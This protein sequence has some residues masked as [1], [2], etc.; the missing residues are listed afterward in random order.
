MTTGEESVNKNLAYYR[1]CFDQIKVGKNKEGGK[2]LNQPILL[3]SVIDLITQ[4]LLNE[5]NITVSEPLINTFKRYWSVLSSDRFEE[6]NF[7]IPFFHLKNKTPKFWHVKFSEQYTGGRPYNIDSLRRDVEKA[8]ID[9]ELFDLLRDYNAKKELIDILI[10]AWFS[11]SQKQIEDVLTI[12]QSLQD[13]TWNELESIESSDTDAQ[14]KVYLRKSLFREAIFR[15]SVVHL[16]DYRC[17]FCRLKVTNRSL[18]Q[19][20]VDGAHIKPFSE[21]YD[22]RPDNGLSLCKNHHWAFDRGW[23]AVDD[24]YQII[25]DIDLQ[26]DSPHARLMK[27]FHGELILLPSSEKDYPRKDA[28]QWH[29]KNVF[30]LNQNGKSKRRSRK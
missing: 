19:S 9:D 23:L 13:S 2:A 24:R 6:I 3:L 10:S 5:N 20:I 11:S 8:K 29:R 28:L 15:K 21:F 25:V 26:E 14:P 16:Y 27:E 17:A 7:T 30:T 18:S 4:G 22:N 1:N 12:N